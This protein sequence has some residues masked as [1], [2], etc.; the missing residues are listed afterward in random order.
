MCL[1]AAGSS[2]SWTGLSSTVVSPLSPSFLHTT[3]ELHVK[4]PVR[5]HSRNSWILTAETPAEAPL[6]EV[7]MMRMR[8]MS[9]S[10]CFLSDSEDSDTQVRLELIQVW[11][12]MSVCVTLTLSLAAGVVA[13]ATFAVDSGGKLDRL[14]SRG[15]GGG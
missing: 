13:V 15:G 2:G 7:M 3:T 14:S 8:T 9:L 10:C 11:V 6:E 4:P 12:C 1:T 5:P